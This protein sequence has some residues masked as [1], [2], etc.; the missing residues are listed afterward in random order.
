MSGLYAHT[1]DHEKVEGMVASYKEGMEKKEDGTAHDPMMM[2][3][4]KEIMVGGEPRPFSLTTMQDL[5]RE[6]T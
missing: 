2:G 6:K 3:L 1:I 5:I 4:P